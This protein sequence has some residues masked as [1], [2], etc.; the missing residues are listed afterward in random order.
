MPNFPEFGL[1][2]AI[3]ERT[4]G[5]VCRKILYFEENPCSLSSHVE[6]VHKVCR[7]QTWRHQKCYDPWR[8][9]FTRINMKTSCKLLRAV[10]FARCV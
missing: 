10:R 1:T 5:V 4:P 2:L 3:D 8:R 7:A 6:L 9:G